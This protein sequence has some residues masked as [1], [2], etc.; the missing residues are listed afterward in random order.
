MENPDME[1]W[2]EN[3]ATWFILIS[4]FLVNNFVQNAWYVIVKIASKVAGYFV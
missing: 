3:L 4:L 1:I 2:L